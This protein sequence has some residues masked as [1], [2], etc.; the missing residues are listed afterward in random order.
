LYELGIAPGLE[1]AR[2]KLREAASMAVHE[3]QSRM[4]ENMVGRSRAFWQGNYPRLAE[5]AGGAAPAGAL[6]GVGIDEFVKAI[7]K[8]EPSF[9]RTEAD[10]VT[11]SL[12]IILR[13]ELES[14]LVSGRLAVKDL[15]AAWNAKMKELLGVVPP[16]DTRGCLQDVH[17]SAGLFGYFPS[18]ALGNLYAAQLW[19][20]MKK[21]LSDIDSRIESGDLASL[22]AWLRKNIHEPGATYL[23][24]ELIQRVTGSS[25][26]PKHFMAYLNEKY[27]RIYAF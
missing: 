15:P 5:L 10:E 4:W 13:F 9:I 20:T 1:F 17:W 23:P 2:S 6:V 19:S 12:H 18:Y 25:L 3:S 26:D 16:D 7:N 14:D 24:G 22:L 21:S 8:V 27:S 11:Y